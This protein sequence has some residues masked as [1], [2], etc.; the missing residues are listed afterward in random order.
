MPSFRNDNSTFPSL[1]LIKDLPIAVAV[2]ECRSGF[3]LLVQRYSSPKP[4][5]K[6]V[7]SIW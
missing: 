3:C 2:F 5:Q 7:P 1:D 6:Q 4:T